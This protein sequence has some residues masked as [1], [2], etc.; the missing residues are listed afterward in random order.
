MFSKSKI[1]SSFCDGKGFCQP[2]VTPS[3]RNI[4]ICTLS[5]NL[6]DF[7]DTEGDTYSAKV[8]TYMESF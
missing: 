2:V 6:R 4:H 5:E 8:V 7:R 1:S 3:K